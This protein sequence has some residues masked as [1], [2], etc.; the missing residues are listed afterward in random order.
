M[1]HF[2]PSVSYEGFS[3]LGWSSEPV[4][5]SDSLALK[6]ITYERMLMHLAG[7]TPEESGLKRSLDTFRQ[8]AFTNGYQ[9]FKTPDGKVLLLKALH[10][11]TSLLLD[12]KTARALLSY[13]E[14]G[15]IS[16]EQRLEMT[17]RCM[18]EDLIRA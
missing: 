3:K 12:G 15:Y 5:D 14:N 8:D 16:H 18:P 6:F 4:P 7:K 10:C 9:I 13:L 2:Q 17:I 11:E 1:V